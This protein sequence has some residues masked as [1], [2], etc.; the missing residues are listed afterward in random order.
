MVHEKWKVTEEGG[1]GPET[2]IRKN[3]LKQ[4]EDKKSKKGQKDVPRL[5]ISLVNIQGLTKPKVLE[6]E[7]LIQQN[8]DLICLTEMQQ[9]YDK[10]HM[11]RGIGK[12]E[13]MRERDDKKEGVY[14]LCTK[15]T[16]STL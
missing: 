15:K 13:S 5:V 10:L 8:W 1:R 2:G 7:Q 6:L 9:K 4:E 11:S 3:T 16:I 12:V 14:S